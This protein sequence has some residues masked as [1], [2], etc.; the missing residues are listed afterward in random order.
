MLQNSTF[1]VNGSRV[2]VGTATPETS[3]HVLTSDTAS[4]SG[5]EVLRLS[6]A[7]TA[8]TVGS[9]PRI[10]FTDSD[11]TGQAAAL[12]AYTFSSSATGLAFETGFNALGVRMVINN[13][14]NV[15]I[16]TT[17]PRQKH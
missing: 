8:A 16:N 7:T 11:G 5:Q 15:G 12:R 1:F 6:A 13:A 4:T 9:G 3:L 2:G 14:G 10:I 17:S